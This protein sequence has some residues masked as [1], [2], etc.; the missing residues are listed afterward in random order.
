[1]VKQEKTALNVPVK[2][3]TGAIFSVVDPIV[4]EQEILMQR[5][6]KPMPPETCSG[7]K[8]MEDQAMIKVG[9]C[10]KSEQI[11]MF[12]AVIQ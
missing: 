3:P 11:P 4:L 9:M 6:T 8:D 7:P 12:F 5:Y 1:M 10:G 2:H